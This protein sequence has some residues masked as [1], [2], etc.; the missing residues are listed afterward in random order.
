MRIAYLSTFYPFR[1]G[2]AQ[3]NASLYSALAV[4]HTVHPFTFTTQYPSFLF[5]G[6]TQM[7]EKDDPVTTIKSVP[8]LSTINPFSYYKTAR[9][10]NQFNPD[11]LLMKYW[12]SFFGPSLGT[13]AKNMLPNTKIIAI[14]DNLIPHEKR[15]VDQ[16]FNTFF[17]N[18]LDGAIVM[19]AQVYNDAK[20][21]IPDNKICLLQHPLYNHFG[22][23]IDKQIARHKLK[24]FADKK[25]I[26]FFGF[27][28]DYKGLDLLIDAF[29]NL[30]DDYQLLIAGE[31]YGSFDTYQHQIN[32]LPNKDQVFVWNQYISDSMVPL[33]F[34]A[35][36]VCILPYRSATQSGISAIAEFYELPQI[37]TRVGGLHET[38]VPNKTGVVVEEANSHLIG[39]AISNFFS[40]NYNDIFLPYIKENK[41]KKSWT[42]LATDIEVFYNKLGHSR[43]I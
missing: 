31:V 17:L 5:P 2:I 32:Q 38:I 30:G 10:I 18:Q 7:V 24:I 22:E 39:Q 41:A 33:L 35:S 15:I 14:L 21:K 6:T 42:Q 12:M 3:F 40:S 34:S 4:N 28:R 11:M 25:T 26:L 27:I 23:K 13:V 37:V 20:K 8:I 29:R 9:V 36:D 1:G 19:S 16:F 43:S